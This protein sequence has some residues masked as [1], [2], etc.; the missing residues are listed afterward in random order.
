MNIAENKNSNSYSCRT[1]KRTF[2]VY[3]SGVVRR[4][5]AAGAGTGDTGLPLATAHDPPDLFIERLGKAE[6]TFWCFAALICTL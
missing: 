3:S 6:C 2:H 4:R 1:R 5:I